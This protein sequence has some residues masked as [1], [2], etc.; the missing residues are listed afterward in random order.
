VALEATSES[1]MK[2]MFGRISLILVLSLLLA[3]AASISLDTRRS[4]ETLQVH[5]AGMQLQGSSSD[6]DE[7][8][9]AP[10]A[11]KIETCAESGC[12]LPKMELAQ[13]R[14][15][16]PQAHEGKAFMA[17]VDAIQWKSKD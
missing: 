11:D 7:V 2:A 4:G 14:F 16:E 10:D 8:S 15:E 1:E 9:A 17:P 6:M 12:A 13:A 5:T 3:L